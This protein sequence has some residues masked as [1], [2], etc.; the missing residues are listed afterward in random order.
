MYNEKFL[1][2]SDRE[3]AAHI[4]SLQPFTNEMREAQDELYYRKNCT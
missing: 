1:N 3:L 2:M 4:A